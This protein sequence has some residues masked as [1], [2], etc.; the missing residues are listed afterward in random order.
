MAEQIKASSLLPF[1]KRRS[2][3]IDII[4]RLKS[5]YVRVA[6]P[7][8]RLS[9]DSTQSSQHDGEEDFDEDDEIVTVQQEQPSPTSTAN[10]SININEP[11]EDKVELVLHVHVFKRRYFPNNNKNNN[12][13]LLRCNSS[14]LFSI[15]S[16]LFSPSLSQW[17][18]SIDTIENVLIFGFFCFSIIIRWLVLFAFVFLSVMNNLIAYSF[19][20]ISDITSHYYH[21][22]TVEVI[23]FVSLLK[24]MEVDQY[25]VIL[26][27]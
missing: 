5:K 17:N 24:N 4:R 3:S 2:F 27:A 21:I 25:S 15:L 6:H 14:T 7:E 19:S 26:F 8:S 18:C 10:S 13:K 16:S 9:T 23:W 20:P 11:L 12:S 1:L 22:G